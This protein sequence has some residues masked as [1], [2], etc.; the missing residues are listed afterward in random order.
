M[1]RGVQVLHI[2]LSRPFPPFPLGPQDT[3]QWRV[4][5]GFSWASLIPPSTQP[6]TGPSAQITWTVWRLYTFTTW[7]RK[8]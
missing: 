5:P 2:L 6:G 8:L 7:N 3:R 1:A 4:C